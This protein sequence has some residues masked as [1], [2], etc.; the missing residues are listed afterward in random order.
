MTTTLLESDPETALTLRNRDLICL[1]HDWNGDPLSKTHLM[2]L[3]AQN[4]RVLWV[5][6]IGY[7][8]PTLSGADARRALN[9]LRA[10]CRPL[11]EVE[12]NLFVLNPLAIPMHHSTLV[13]SINR[14]LLRGQIRR[15]MRALRFERPISW[16]FNPAAAVVAGSLGEDLLIYYCVD[17]YPALAGVAAESLAALESRLLR[18]ADVVFVS[19]DRLLR[20][21]APRARRCHLVRHGVD[22]RNFRRALGDA[23]PLPPDIASLPHPIVG[24][25]GLMSA[26]WIDVALLERIAQ[27]FATGSLVLIGKVAMDM[28][29][30]TR[31][32]NVHFLGSKPFTELP[33]Y[34]RAF[35]VGIVPFPI[36]EL[37]L[38]AN[39]LKAR[40]Y[41]AAGLPVVSTAIPEVEQLEHCLV[42]DDHDSFVQSIEAALAERTSRSERSQSMR[43]QTWAHRLDEICAHLEPWLTES[44]GDSP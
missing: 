26:D 7:R 9:K 42:A 14:Q 18:N 29:R 38:A 19:S 13:G 30:L 25:F 12:P 31:Y 27:R 5:N 23:L 11:V 34:C 33:D 16:I 39:P 35:D 36:S 2:R 3:L 1:S 21:K 32:P 17:E 37:T 43:E 8:A 10:A 24:Y 4:N 15:A 20:S 22:Y 40:E 28:S 44:A 41:L 6:S